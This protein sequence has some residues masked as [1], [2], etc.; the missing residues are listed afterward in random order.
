[1]PDTG[2]VSCWIESEADLENVVDLFRIQY[3]RYA[4]AKRPT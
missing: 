1:L 4:A 2:W 3:E